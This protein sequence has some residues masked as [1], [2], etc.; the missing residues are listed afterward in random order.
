LVAGPRRPSGLSEK[1]LRG[2]LSSIVTVLETYV[3][4]GGVLLLLGIAAIKGIY[5][6]SSGS[7][8][9]TLIEF[10]VLTLLL[11]RTART[12]RR[13]DQRHE[14]ADRALQ[15]NQRRLSDTLETIGDGFVTFDKDWRFTYV[16]SKAENILRLSRGDLLGNVVWEVFP[17]KVQ[18]H[19]Y[20]QLLTAAKTRTSV[21]FE[22]YDP[23]LQ[24]WFADKAYPTKD[25]GL[26]VY[27]EDIT[28]Q[29]EAEQA[30]RDSQNQLQTELND[31]RLLQGVSGAI[32]SEDDDGALYGTILDAAVQIMR[33]DFGSMQ[34]LYP[35]RGNGE[36]RLLA[37]RGFP[38]EA[39]QFWEWVRT[40][41]TCTC[42]IAFQ[43]HERVMVPDVIN[44]VDAIDAEQR[45]VYEQAGIRA[46]QS[47]PLLS[48]SGQLVGMI[49]THWNKPHRPSDRDFRVF[50]ILAR[51]ASDLLERKS[52]RE[53]ALERERAARVE[54]ERAVRMKDDFLATVSHELRTPLNAILGWSHV[55]KRD[56]RNPENV[57]TAAEV[58][59]RNGRLQAQLIEDLLD[60]S[61]VLSGKMRLD[62]QRIK[63]QQ[64]IDSA[65]ESISPTADVKG[66]RIT[67]SLD[68]SIA[69]T[70][71][72]PARLQ[73]VVWN[74]LSNAVKFT[75]P[76]G[77]IDISLV[78]T[79][80]GVEI[81]ISDTGEGISPEFLPH[82]FDR[83]R[84]ADSSASRTHGGL[85]IGLALVRQLVE[86]HGGSVR[87][88]SE[89]EGRGA[90]FVIALPVV[91]SHGDEK[92]SRVPC[93]LPTRLR[94]IRVLVVDDEADAAAMV[95]RIL[96]ENEALVTTAGSAL[97]ALKTLSTLSFDVIV[98]DIGM[99]GRD[100]YGFMGDVRRLGIETPAI[101]LTAY[102]RPEDREKSFSSG[103]QA[104]VS[105]P[106]DIGELLD[107]VASLAQGHSIDSRLVP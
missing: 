103:Y 69:T 5:D 71:G 20:Q 48:R 45:A 4:L 29:K 22:D 10:V 12:I 102:A 24:R 28:Y 49:S 97:E 82:L 2:K 19:A 67:R 63:L 17:E 41:S 34:M 100:G 62:I 84:Q 98:S 15:E 56:I 94:G 80:V 107:S 50:D 47:T 40:D 3:L 104:H 81:R 105:K 79:T 18:S 106:A 6:E 61:R 89:G 52:S 99:P 66:I 23:I 38:P 46:V 7:A 31:T 1:P 72:D 86:L 39:A 65:V 26:A 75:P 91:A 37:F 92:P 11:W 33:S 83:F 58:I 95:R 30:L 21:A 70:V 55:L 74:V 68:P 73:Q 53:Q 76:A 25:G 87:A 101:A 8:V 93:D 44:A 16:N 90:T 43:T 64:V 27:F 88:S 32:V 35:Q 54:A 85:G 60:M 59:E 13:Q 36:L 14:A 78:R 42:G 9:R 51:Q 57:A 96:H 77:S